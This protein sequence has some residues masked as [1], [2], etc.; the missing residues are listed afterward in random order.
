MFWSSLSALVFGTITTGEVLH[1]QTM[2]PSDSTY[3]LIMGCDHDTCGSPSSYAGYAESTSVAQLESS[4]PR[5]TQSVGRL[6]SRSP[7]STYWS[8]THAFSSCRE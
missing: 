5:I 6:R 2:R 8:T 3:T 7:T 4:L 1:A